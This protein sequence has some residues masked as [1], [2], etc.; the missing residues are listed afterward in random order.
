MGIAFPHAFDPMSSAADRLALYLAAEAAI[1]SGGQS[2]RVEHP[3]GGRQLT[4]ADLA[5]V[6][7]EIA[8]LQ[9][10]VDA[11]QREAMGM[12]SFRFSRAVFHD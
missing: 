5:E 4:F 1:L 11:E 2:A 12:P 7:A 8:L 9:R 6:R 3:N 10:A